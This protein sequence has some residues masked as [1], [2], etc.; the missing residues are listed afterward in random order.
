MKESDVA[1]IAARGAPV[2]CLDTCTIL[3]LMRDPTRDNVNPIERQTALDLF[4][5]A[6]GGAHLV[7]L[8]ADQVVH[9]FGHHAQSVEDEAKQALAKLKAKL[10]RIDAVA[11]AYGSAG[12]SA[13]AHLDD[14]VR[15]ARAVV[16]RWLEVAVPAGQG[17]DIPGRAFARLN[18]ARTPARKG[19]DSM[20]DCVVIETYLEAAAKLRS[21]RLTQPIVFVS[22]N[23]KDYAGENGSVLK[24]DLA[25][26]FGALGMEYAPNLSAAKHHLGL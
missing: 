17:A 7:A 12:T 3:D 24:P 20:K 23:V 21:A 26:E 6:E 25:A 5:A 1:A 15:R 11:A 4:V 22:S 19:K 16:D 10:A 2:L 14:H 13:F 8:L 9:E 18:Q